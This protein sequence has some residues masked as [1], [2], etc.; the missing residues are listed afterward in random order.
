MY[1]LSDFDTSV[2]RALREINPNYMDYPGFVICGSHTPHDQEK[3]LEIISQCRQTGTPLLAICYGFQLVAI[4]Y[5]RNVLG[6]EDA[7]SE[8]WDKEGTFVIKK[9]DGLK[10]GWK[11]GETWWSNYYVDIDVDMPDNFFAAPYHPEYQSWKGKPHDLLVDFLLY[12][13]QV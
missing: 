10:V 9:R 5:A 7:T 11:D 4:E 2:K 12:A 3:Y 6:I 13:S 1:V 8:E